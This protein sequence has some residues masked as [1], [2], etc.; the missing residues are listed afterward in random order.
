MTNIERLPRNWLLSMRR[1]ST[2]SDAF[3]NLMLLYHPDFHTVYSHFLGDALPS[4]WGAAATTGAGSATTVASGKM[5]LTTDTAANDACGQGY[6]LFWKGNLG[7]H[8]ETLVDLPSTAAIAIEA[9]ITDSLADVG[10]IA[11][12]T[13]PTAT[14]TDTVVIAYDTADP[15]QPT[16]VDLISV[17]TGVV[18]R[19][20]QN[21]GVDL[22]ASAG[23]GVTLRGEGDTVFAYASGASQ[24]RDLFLGSGEISGA[25]DITPWW[26]VKTRTTAAKILNSSWF[27]M[28]GP[29]GMVT[30]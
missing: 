11:T 4:E 1:A 20:R 17:K 22:S 29:S 7:F 16:Y 13:A 18:T 24:G 8:F 27:V 6:G 9:G 30:R 12:K 26:F 19:S 10:A 23:I 15:V 28:T 21:T 25:V 3:G 5:T 2:A 14:A